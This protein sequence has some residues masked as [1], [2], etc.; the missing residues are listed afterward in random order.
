MH[1]VSSICRHDVY[2]KNDVEQTKKKLGVFKY[3]QQGSLGH[4]RDTG[5][6]PGPLTMAGDVPSSAT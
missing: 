1:Q 2:S 5:G 4:E 6:V 3:K